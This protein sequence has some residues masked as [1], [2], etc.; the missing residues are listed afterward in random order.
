LSGSSLS[1]GCVEDFT[2]LLEKGSF[3]MMKFIKELPPAVAKVKLQLKSPFG[4]PKDSDKTDVGLTV[5]CI[6]ALPE[7]PAEIQ[8]LLK[9]ISLKIGLDF[10]ADAAAGIADSSIPANVGTEGGSG[11][12]K[13]LRNFVSISFVA[14]GLG[15]LIYGISQNSEVKNSV[16]KK[17]G[18]KAV[19]AEKNRNMGYGIGAG[20]LVGGIT[21]FVVF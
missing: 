14:V 16:D 1:K 21:V 8:S 10:V 3:D 20:L 13:A 6:K 2:N 11:G 19:K 18:E 9:D 17:D 15:T 5:G 4:K 12:G 7:S